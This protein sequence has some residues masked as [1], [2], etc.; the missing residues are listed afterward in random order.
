M[1]NTMLMCIQ[2]VLS[3]LCFASLS[4]SGRDRDKLCVN[5]RVSVVGLRAQGRCT[6]VP[7]SLDSLKALTAKKRKATEEVFGGKKYVK[8]SEIEAA[9]LKKLREEEQRELEAKAR[10]GCQWARAGCQWA[11]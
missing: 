3:T 6:V 2:H 5:Y 11:C 9:H 10:A 1:F 4:A 7:M 8:R